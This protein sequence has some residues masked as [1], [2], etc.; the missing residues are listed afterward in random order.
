MSDFTPYLYTILKNRNVVLSNEDIEEII[1]DVFVAV[2]KN[3][4]R[5]DWSSEMK[6]YLVGITRNMMC[7]KMK[8]VKFDCDISEFEN[9]LSQ[10]EN[11]EFEVENAEKESLILA[12]LNQ[13]KLEDREIFMLYYYYWSKMVATFLLTIGITSGLVFATGKVAET[14]WK[15]PK[16]YRMNQNLSEEEK[17]KCISEKE[18]E[19]I[20]NSYL[21]K[22][23]LTDENVE[24][25]DLSKEF[26]E[27]ENVWR[28]H[29]EKASITIDAEK[30]IVKSVQIPTWEYK[31]P[32]NFG[33]TRQEARKIAQELLEKYRPEEDTGDYEMV[34]LR[35]N[36]ETDEG[37]YIWYADFH[38]KY[39]D[40]LNEEEAIFIGWIPTING[41]YTLNLKQN[42]YENN[43]EKITKDDAIKIATRKDNLIETV[44][45]IKNTKA[46]IRIKKMNENVYLR[47]NFKEEY[48]KGRLNLEK[49]GENTY[50]FKKDA[51]FYET[52]ERVRKVWCVVVEY[53]VTE[54]T[55]MSAFTYY[56]DATTG[57]IIGGQGGDSLWSEEMT[58]EDEYNLIEK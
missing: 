54:G 40:L 1:S 24:G 21:K 37:S 8:K 50:Q 53:D 35:R 3:Q 32:Y 14:I 15:E 58:K 25:L 19:E 22:I 41:L 18:A 44:K 51:V 56:I 2:W 5:L 43:E 13:M 10:T 55:T 47:E 7:K 28:M 16:S 52:E 48:E 26:F 31:I 4:E 33:I 38:K 46:E 12:E 34:T 57:E 39:G 30:G 42:V 36:M 27:N 20:G 29:S 9:V 49:T 6:P 45:N 23:G 17:Q 11:V